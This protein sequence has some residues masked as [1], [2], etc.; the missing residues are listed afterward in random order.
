MSICVF[1][2]LEKKTKVPLFRPDLFLQRSFLLSAIPNSWMVGF[3]WVVFFLIPLYLQNMVGYTPLKVG[4]LLLLV[5][6]P[7]AFLSVPVTK[8]YRKW[9]AKPLVLFGF[10]ILALSSLSQ[11]LFITREA[12]WPIGLGCLGIG[13]GWVLIWGPS[14]S[15]SL[16]SIPHNV[17]G[18]ASGM[19]TTLQELGAVISLAIGG[20]FFQMTYHSLLAPQMNQINA[21]LY[22]FSSDQIESLITNPVAVE[23]YLGESSPILPILREGFLGGYQ[24]AF[25]FLFGM[26]LL[27]ML[28]SLFLPK[29]APLG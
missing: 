13:I 8:L 15:C 4:V 23:H 20:V 7:V 3:I 14:I 9:G 11:S 10:S 25:W 17:A 2:V 12:F 6:L 27:A 19:F 18:I 22:N 5:T 21:A 28:L 1:V 24:N 26:S 29:K 16:S